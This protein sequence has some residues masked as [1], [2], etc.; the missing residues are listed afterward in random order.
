MAC[1][2]WE[3]THLTYDYIHTGVHTGVIPV[4]PPDDHS[5]PLSTR[6]KLNNESSETIINCP[7]HLGVTSIPTTMTTISYNEALRR[8]LISKTDEQKVNG[9]YLWLNTM[10][11]V[12]KVKEE[13]NENQIKYFGPTVLVTKPNLSIRVTHDYSALK[14]MTSLYKFQQDEDIWTWASGR[15][16]LIKLDFIKAFHSVEIDELDQPFYGFIGPDLK[17]YYY[18]VLPMGTRN[19][20]ALFAEFVTKSLQ[21]G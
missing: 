14:P 21:P 5:P 7:V 20:S 13:S 4:T 11:Q 16:F 9:Y 18:T 1:I 2:F 12:K 17:K 3:E 8:Q 15:S 19:S 10:I 6:T